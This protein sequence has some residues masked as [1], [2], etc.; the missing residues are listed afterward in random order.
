MVWAMTSEEDDQED[1]MDRFALAGVR[2]TMEGEGFPTI[3]VGIFLV[4]VERKGGFPGIIVRPLVLAILLRLTKNA[5]PMHLSCTSFCL[6]LLV[7][8]ALPTGGSL[9]SAR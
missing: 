4:L 2:S 7:Q 6:A 3:Y 9:H 5:I 1:E 8:F